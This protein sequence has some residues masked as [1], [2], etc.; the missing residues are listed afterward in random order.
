[1]CRISFALLLAVALFSMGCGRSKTST[2]PDGETTTVTKKGDNVDVTFTGKNDDK[3]Q[4]TSSEKGVAL[5]DNFPKDAPIYPDAK[6]T[7]STTIPNGFMVMLET[8]D[9]LEQVKEFYED[10]LKLEGW[11]TETSLNLPQNTTLANK[12]DARTLTLTISAGDKTMIQ[13]LVTQEKEL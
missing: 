8:N 7:M 4:I 5:P 3:L 9:S 1:M 12:K 6:A 10:K 13:L 11:E 2:G